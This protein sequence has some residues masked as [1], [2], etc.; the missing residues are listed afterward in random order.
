MKPLPL[1]RL[2][3]VL[4]VCLAPLSRGRFLS[5]EPASASLTEYQIKAAFLY[6][7]AKFVEWP[8][9]TL[10]KIGDTFTIGIWGEDPFGEDLENELT[11]KMVQGKR[12]VLKKLTRLEDAPKCQVLFISASEKDKLPMALEILKGFSVLTVSD[13]PSFIQRGGM[14]GFILDHNRVRFNINLE[15]AEKSD[16]KISSQLLKLAKT[17][18]GKPPIS[19]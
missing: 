8:A 17:I 3:V 10:E 14:V 19:G 13:I 15:M 7:F 9:P 1:K 4:L 6:N 18:K 2:F 11:G 12:L 5:A 16:L